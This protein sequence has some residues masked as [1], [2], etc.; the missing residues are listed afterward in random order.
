MSVNL[1]VDVQDPLLHVLVMCSSNGRPGSPSCWR[2]LCDQWQQ[3]ASRRHWRRL[4]PLA[5]NVAAAAC[6]AGAAAA[7]AAGAA[8]AA[9]ACAADVL[10]LVLDAVVL[11]PLAADC[12]FVNLPIKLQGS[13]TGSAQHALKS[14]R[15]RHEGLGFRV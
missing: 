2:S 13:P 15:S 14:G 3:F 10:V 12:I 11:L 8:A 6:A 5:A 7:A 9:A 4:W 1:Q